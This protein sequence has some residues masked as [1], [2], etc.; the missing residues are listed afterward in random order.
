MKKYTP[1]VFLTILLGT[2]LLAACSKE[3]NP[4]PSGIIPDSVDLGLSVNWASS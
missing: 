2:C 4:E 1:F 3:D